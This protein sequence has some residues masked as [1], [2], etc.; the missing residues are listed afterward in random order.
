LGLNTA[1]KQALDNKMEEARATLRS[2]QESE[3]ADD[4]AKERSRE[5]E[6]AVG[7]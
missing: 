3:V 2:I 4:Q 1:I 6:S 7:K 5:I